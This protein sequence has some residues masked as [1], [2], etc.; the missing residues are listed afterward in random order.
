MQSLLSRPLS[1]AS[2]SSLAKIDLTERYLKNSATFLQH[3]P[4]VERD[5]K[6]RELE[7]PKTL[8]FPDIEEKEEIFKQNILTYRDDHLGSHQNSLMKSSLTEESIDENV[9]EE[10]NIFSEEAKANEDHTH[11]E[12]VTNVNSLN[13][14]VVK[15]YE[16]AINESVVNKNVVVENVVQKEVVQVSISSTFYAHFFCTKGNRTA[17]SS[18][19]PAL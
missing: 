10:E 8:P 4:S 5:S 9:I 3:R 2:L 12:S 11:N 13:E 7:K 15:D 19:I 1:Q 18:Y 14:N 17:I 16:N 6:E